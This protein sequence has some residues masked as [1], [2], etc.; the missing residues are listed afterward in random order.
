MELLAA[1][2]R[3][4]SPEAEYEIRI[5]N[6]HVYIETYIGIWDK[7]PD[8]SESVCLLR[9]ANDVAADPRKLLEL[10]KTTI[11]LNAGLELD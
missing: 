10:A 3:Y 9:Y 4:Y 7:N 5:I 2:P 1:E 6:H 8:S 11:L